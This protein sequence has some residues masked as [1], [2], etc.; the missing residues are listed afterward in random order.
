MWEVETRVGF[1]PVLV[2]VC[3]VAP[4][5]GEEGQLQEPRGREHAD[6]V[7]G[8]C[9]QPEQTGRLAKASGGGDGGHIGVQT[10][11]RCAWLTVREHR[12][13]FVDTF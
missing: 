3:V 7:P 1:R 10:E 11:G 5:Q 9:R 13:W 4:S 8:G 12:L 6:G 2:A